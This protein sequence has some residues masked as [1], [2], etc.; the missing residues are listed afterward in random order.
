MDDNEQDTIRTLT[1][2]RQAMSNL[3]Q[4]YR[5]RVVDTTG[6]NLLAEFTSAVDAVNCS[7]EIQRELA[8]RNA[9]LSYERKMEF[10]IGVNVGDVVEEEERIYGD[11][12]NIAARVEGLAETGGICISGRVYDQVENKLDLE[13]EYLG[14][15][16]V[17]N[18]ARPIRVY[19]VL[20]LPGAAAHRVVK[21]KAAV[22]KKWRKIVLAAAAVL[23]IVAAAAAVWNYY[24]R[25]SPLETASIETKAIPLPVKPSI[26]VLP[27]D[28]LSGDPEQEYFSDGMTDELINDLAKIS[29]ILVISRNTTFTYKGKQVKIPQIAKELNVRYVLEGSVQKSG[30]QVRIRAQLIDGKTD[31]HLWSESYDGVL[32]DIF[33]L[34]DKV[35][36][37]IVSALALK[38]SP[39]EA[40][41]IAA[42]GTDS[43]IAHDFYMKG[44]AHLRRWTPDSLVKAINYF[45]QAVE[46]DPS[47]SQ[48]YAGLAQAYANAV[49]G[50]KAFYKKIGQE[51]AG[52]RFLMRHYLELAMKNPTSGAY[53]LLAR[54]ELRRRHYNEAIKLAEKAVAIAPNDDYALRTLGLTLYNA[55]RP[56]E[57]I[58][59]IKES[60]RLNPSDT[61]IGN[62]SLGIAYMHMERYEEA[63]KSVEL[64][65]ADNPKLL[66][67]HV[68]S[69]VSYAHLGREDEAKE[70]LNKYLTIYTDGWYPDVQSLYYNYSI[71]NPDVF[72]RFVEGLVKAGYKKDPKGYYEVDE[73]NKLN[74]QEIKEL[75]LGNTA[76]FNYM[77]VEW[78]KHY[79]EEGAIE[80]SIPKFGISKKGKCWIEED[81][82]CNQFEEN[83][84]G[85]VKY[86]I[87]IY[88]NPKGNAI[89]KSQYL[90][91]SDAGLVPF[92]IKE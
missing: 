71:K 45:K 25:P 19:R 49:V 54:L 26:A 57:G 31:H 14:E 38:L 4:Q 53:S 84:H 55:D 23:V 48:A 70:A 82:Y 3:I 90:A 73:A 39:S 81:T 79:S 28:N 41:N 58:P 64:S 56:N 16:E 44:K 9:E 34:Q 75:F 35:T 72:N 51:I 46:V 66:H 76:T 69:A 52:S 8:E 89:E 88:Y 59:Y 87:D 62:F 18:I 67:A 33:D 5:V 80:Y 11:G 29:S 68:V 10:R 15:Q 17:K 24:L 7:V 22:R 27:F 2:Y 74:G 86:C 6:D 65:L 43:I 40:D 50:G 20:S 12:V 13:Y 37:K 61:S 32:A 21:A 91:L 77:G 63:I 1:E 78:Y 83:W 36:G 60:M 85:G 30:D 47:Y 42:K 92:S